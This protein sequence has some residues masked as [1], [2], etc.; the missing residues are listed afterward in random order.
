MLLL[1]YSCIDLILINFIQLFNCSF[2]FQVNNKVKKT[3]MSMKLINALARVRL[4]STPMQV[5]KLYENNVY[6]SI[7]SKLILAKNFKHEEN[8]FFFFAEMFYPITYIK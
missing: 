8:I 3:Q 7:I 6:N 2:I 5:I 1:L 4:L